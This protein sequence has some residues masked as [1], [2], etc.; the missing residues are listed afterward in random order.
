MRPTKV[1]R[2]Q[3]HG[4]GAVLKKFQISSINRSRDI[5]DLK[6]ACREINT[7]SKMRHSSFLAFAIQAD[8]CVL[9]IS[10]S[11][12]HVPATF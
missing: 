5:K 4:H 3:V 10:V 11:C 8:M 1:G 7:P 6:I 9:S 12:N 2:Q